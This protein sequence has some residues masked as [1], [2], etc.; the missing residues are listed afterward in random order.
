MDR[1]AVL[2]MAESA[3][4]RK[5]AIWGLIGVAGCIA[6]SK[7]V[8]WIREKAKES[9]SKREAEKA[10]KKLQEATGTD[11]IV[12][13]ETADSIA[14]ALKQSFDYT[15]GTDLET[16]DRQMAQIKNC[17]DWYIVRKAFGQQGYGVTGSPMWGEGEKL[18]LIG[19]CR[20]ELSGAR[21]KKC[22]ELNDEANKMG[23]GGMSNSST[24]NTLL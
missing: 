13:T 9:E 2:A 17:G 3:K 19:W 1:E 14:K 16:F 4:V 8:K 22:E 12:N 18:D 24:G 20:K 10:R 15:F 5:L 23:L 7:L 11:D 21:L 6:V